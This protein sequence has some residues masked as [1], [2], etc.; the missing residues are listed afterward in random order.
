MLAVA[1]RLPFH[2][3]WLSVGHC[4][5]RVLLAR[6]IACV[7]AFVF[8]TCGMMRTPSEEALATSI[9]V[10]GRTQRHSQAV[11]YHQIG[12]QRPEGPHTDRTTHG[13]PSHQVADRGRRTAAGAPLHAARATKQPQQRAVSERLAPTFPTGASP[14]GGKVPITW[15]ERS[16]AVLARR[17]AIETE[18]RKK[19][20][21]KDARLAKAEEASRNAKFG[22]AADGGT[23]PPQLSEE[24]QANAS[25]RM[26]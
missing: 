13:P 15:E 10:C 21:M 17:E 2:P 18:K 22:N 26:I 9:R 12:P 6:V 1:H 7:A 14:T 11:S 24:L 16:L 25:T 4:R 20:A 3:D 23:S 5:I 8:T 19:V